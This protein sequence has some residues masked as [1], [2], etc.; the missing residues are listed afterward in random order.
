MRGAKIVDRARFRAWVLTLA[1]IGLIVPA[2]AAGAVSP[3][4]ATAHPAVP[5][6]VAAARYLAM[7]RAGFG[8]PAHAA[9][10]AAQATAQANTIRARRVSTRVSSASFGGA[11]SPLGP[12]PM[13]QS[14][15]GTPNT[16]R[17]DSLAVVPSGPS[18]GEIFMGAAGGGVWSSTNNGATWQT[19]TDSVSTGLAIGALAIDPNAPATVYAG[20]GEANNCGD[21]FYG[22][23][24][25]KSTDGGNSWSVENPGSVFSGV[26]FSSIEVDPNNSQH[27]WATTTAGLYESANG[28]A[29]WAQPAG[30]TSSN[31]AH[32][33]ILDSTTTPTTVYVAT[34]GVGIQKSID[35]GTTF[36]TLGGGLPSSGTFGDTV[37]GAGTNSTSFPSAN[38]T[39]Y[40]AI[41]LSGST[42]PNGGD[43]SMYKSIDGGTTWTRLTIPAYTNQSYAYGS[44]TADQAFYD[45]TLAVDPANP[46]HVLAAGI[47]MVESTNGGASWSNVNGGGFFSVATNVL[48]PDFHALT[49][50]PSGNAVI[51]NDG[52]VYEYDPS[53]PGPTGVSNLNTNQDTGQ[54]YEDL[55][56]YNNGAQVLGGLQDNG[57]VLFTGGSAWPEELAGDGG[58]SAINP[59][60]ANQQFG[61]G[62]ELLDMTSDDWGTSSNITPPGEPTGNFVPPMV[63]VPNLVTADAPTV[64]YGGGSLNAT[65]DPGPSP[66]WSDLLDIGVPVSAIAIAP[67]NPA[68]LYV[69]FDDGTLEVSTNATSG[70]PTFTAITPPVSE[71]ITHIAVDPTNPGSIAVSF[72]DSNTR[73]VSVPP[74]VDIG[75]VTLTGTP[76]ATY[77]DITGNLP[78]G[79][80]SNSVVFDAGTLVVATDVGVFSTATPNGSS[81]SWS[82]VGTGLPNVQVIGLS[83]SGNG[84]LYVGTHGRGVWKLATGTSPAPTVTGVSP[85]SGPAA[86]GTSVTITGTGF[87]GASA[88]KFGTASAASFTVSTATQIT[89]TTPAGSGKVDT[90]VTTAVSTSAANAADRFTYVVPGQPAVSLGGSGAFGNQALST[91]SSPHTVTVSNVGTGVLAVPAA[92]ISLNGADASQYQL[93]SDT[94]SGKA[95]GSGAAC[96]VQVSFAPSTAGAH[97]NAR[98]QVSDNASSGPQTLALSGTGTRSAPTMHEPVVTQLKQSSRRWK[99]GKA[100]PK[101]LSTA[102]KAAHGHKP[103]VGTVFTFK[104]SANSKVRLAFVQHLRHHKTKGRGSVTLSSKAGTVRISF[105][106]RVSRHQ[107]LVPGSYTVSITATDSAGKSTTHKLTFTLV[108]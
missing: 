81:T 16:G 60:D 83:V 57:T 19:H 23:G 35:G 5:N 74:M 51:G 33:L 50:A 6:P 24:V 28:G 90:T 85:S 98:V 47:T 37:L 59:Q 96:T 8:S 26:D 79:V 73:A 104:L 100:L 34:N 11:W 69:G 87:S 102:P 61:E 45:N 56:I 27:I 66:T 43:L 55:S 2:A 95:I 54:V 97:D 29:S 80:A 7:Q 48:H 70:S 42:D 17:V 108:K 40:A 75:A 92:G 3:L 103:P 1:M 65:N 101:L 93:S 107:R 18:A 84:D 78:S 106:G 36:T 21:C 12:S 10:L 68:I 89:A 14:F 53:T 44:G 31:A 71:W 82:V 41:E 105:D 4:L 9:R 64:Y 32:G 63:L 94:C 77:T 15:Y 58:Y 30:D 62:D 86:G 38:Q 52:G 39:L 22:G 67:S 20:T 99:A 49:F 76:S 25:L 13:T 91:T 88:V 46:S 72:S